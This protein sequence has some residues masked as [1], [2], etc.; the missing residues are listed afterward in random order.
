MMISKAMKS[1][2][3]KWL[4]A[5]FLQYIVYLVMILGLVFMEFV[6]VRA[7]LGAMLVLFI[8]IDIMQDYRIIR[9]LKRKRR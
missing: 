6:L 9:K 3:G 8:G 1:Y 2:A 4:E 7:F 5:S